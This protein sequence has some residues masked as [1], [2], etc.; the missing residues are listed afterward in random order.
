[1]VGSRVEWHLRQGYGCGRDRIPADE[2]GYPGNARLPPVDAWH[3]SDLVRFGTVAAFDFDSANVIVANDD[4]TFSMVPLVCLKRNVEQARS[5]KRVTGW[6]DIVREILADGPLAYSALCVRVAE[7]KS[8]PIDTARL[9]V[10]A[11]VQ[12]AKDIERYDGVCRIKK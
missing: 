6:T 3:E 10:N 1:M 4:G 12:S 2:W 9:W 11:V 7:R 8:V 5:H